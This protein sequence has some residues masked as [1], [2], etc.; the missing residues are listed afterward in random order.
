MVGS[1][2]VTMQAY[3]LQL[4]SVQV[5]RGIV[6]CTALTQ[7]YVGPM[8]TS[9]SNSAFLCVL[10]GIKNLDPDSQMLVLLQKNIPKNK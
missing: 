4:R 1:V 6:A 10:L 9:T 2:V 3:G 8:P 7:A 5:S